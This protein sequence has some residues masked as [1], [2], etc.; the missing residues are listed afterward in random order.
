MRKTVLLTVIAL[1]AVLG[2]CAEVYRKPEVPADDWT[3]QPRGI[4]LARI[5]RGATNIVVAPLDI[6]ATMVRVCRNREEFGYSAGLCQGTFNCL[7][8]LTAGAGEMLTFTRYDQPEPFYR[9]H[10]GE[11]ALPRDEGPGPTPKPRPEPPEDLAA[12][13]APAA[14]SPNP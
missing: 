10:L 8:R 11:P 6:P 2:G 4:P 5:G 12:A 14:D 13:G 3:R 1:A 7:A 9:R